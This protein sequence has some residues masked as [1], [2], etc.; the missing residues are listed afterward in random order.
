MPY[1]TPRRVG[2]SIVE[3]MISLAIVAMLLTAVAAAFTASSDLIDHNDQFFR[4]SQAGRVSMNQMLTQIRRATDV[5]VAGNDIGV[6]YTDPNN[7]DRDVTYRYDPANK[8]LLLITNDITTDPD[9]HLANNVTACTFSAETATDEA[10]VDH[11]VRVTISMTVAVQDNQIRLSGSA[12]VRRKQ[13]Y[14]P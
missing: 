10:G 13:D 11:T 4:A 12:A 5:G 1:P 6:N 2:L 14:N 3:V 7:V 8:R 9:Y